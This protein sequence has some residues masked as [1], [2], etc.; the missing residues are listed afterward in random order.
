MAWAAVGL[1]RDLHQPCHSAVSMSRNFGCGRAT[2]VASVSDSDAWLPEA[3]VAADGVAS[4]S[5]CI[6]M[7]RPKNW[8]G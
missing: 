8:P 2:G 7:S 3:V 6:M 4:E 1:D 5:A